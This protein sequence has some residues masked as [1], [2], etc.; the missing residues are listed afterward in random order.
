MSGLGKSV[1]GVVRMASVLGVIACSMQVL[2]HAE[3]GLQ[4]I[5]VKPSDRAVEPFQAGWGVPYDKPEDGRILV[6]EGKRLVIEFISLDIS[7]DS[8][9]RVSFASILTKAGGSAAGHTI[10]TTAHI[11]YP[12]RNVDLLG[13]MI[14]L[15]SDPGSTVDVRYGYSGTSC[16]EIGVVSV[17]GYFEAVPPTPQQ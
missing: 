11:E 8:D 3:N 2:S 12:T 13:Q 5:S 1:V 15:R 10:P 16:A 17:S 14:L 9:C 7:V 4:T 6:P